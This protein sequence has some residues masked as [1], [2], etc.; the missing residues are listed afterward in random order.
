MP[1]GATTRHVLSF[2]RSYS[3]EDEPEPKDPE[4]SGQ[5]PDQRPLEPVAL[6]LRTRTGPR[7]WWSVGISVLGSVAAMMAIGCFCALAYPI[8]KEL[9]AETVR[10][11][12]G[13]Q[14]RILGFWSILVL[15][16]SIGGI[17]GVFCWTLT[18]IDSREGSAGLALSMTQAKCGEAS[19][20]DSYLD[21][22]V[23]VLNGII[24]FLTVIWSLT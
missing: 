19:L 24:G 15:S 10:G 22:G 18:C 12:D 2:R 17:C 9:R 8:I 5:N 13:T 16:V 11:Q 3:S 20:R 23:A 14:Q 4:V 21:L 6:Q 1:R 7:L